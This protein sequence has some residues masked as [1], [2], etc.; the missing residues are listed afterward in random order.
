LATAILSIS[1]PA[2]SAAR[3]SCQ[4]GSAHST[5]PADPSIG[6]R[7]FKPRICRYGMS[8]C[9]VHAAKRDELRAAGCASVLARMAGKGRT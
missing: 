6:S 8:D 4:S 1:M 3:A 7:Y 2:N 5:V 9:A